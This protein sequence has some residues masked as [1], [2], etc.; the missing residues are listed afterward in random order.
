MK[1]SVNEQ[2]LS[3]NVTYRSHIA[4]AD[5]EDLRRKQ[6]GTRLC[7][8]RHDC[9]ELLFVD[10]PVLVKVK[11]VDHGFTEVTIQCGP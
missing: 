7:I 2:D 11:F 4:R 1:T 9:K 10:F 5:T 3:N 8:I 6:A